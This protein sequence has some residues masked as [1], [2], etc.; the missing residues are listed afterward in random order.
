SAIVMTHNDLAERQQQDREEWR[1]G[2][3]GIV[4]E[5]NPA[6][7]T[8]SIT[9]TLMASGKPILV[10]VSQQTNLLRYAPDSVRFDDAKPGTLD[11]IKPGDQLRARGTK[12]A[13]GS[14]FTASAIVSGRFRDI[15]GTVVSTDAVNKTITINDLTTKQPVVVKVSG[16]SQLRKLP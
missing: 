16:D 14:E 12:S 3:G 6:A 2:V 15:A 1:R 8:L 9:N 11:Q 13:D 5:V 4:K 10:H 7:A